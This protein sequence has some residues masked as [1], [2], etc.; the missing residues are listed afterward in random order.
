[1]S[2][3]SGRTTV[4]RCESEQGQTEERWTITVH[5]IPPFQVATCPPCEVPSDVWGAVATWLAQG[6]PEYGDPD[7]TTDLTGEPT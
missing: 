6:R 7:R 1:M 5:R 3:I 2:L 4:T